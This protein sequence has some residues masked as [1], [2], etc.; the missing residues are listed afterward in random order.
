QENEPRRPP[1]IPSPAPQYRHCA[2][3]AGWRAL[4][5]L[6]PAHW[7]CC[8]AILATATLPRSTPARQRRKRANVGASVPAGAADVVRSR[9]PTHKEHLETTTQ[10]RLSRAR[11][12]RISCAWLVEI[13]IS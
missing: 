1:S 2:R 8:S 11:H 3:S 4:P 13:P 10:K 6:F 7:P 12:F 9:S 5:L